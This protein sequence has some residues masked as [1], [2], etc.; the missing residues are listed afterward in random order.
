MQALRERSRWRDRRVV[1]AILA[2][3]VA[4]GFGVLLIFLATYE[5]RH[6]GRILPG[7]SVDGVSLAGLTPDEAEAR[8]RAELR[9][10]APGMVVLRDPEDE[11]TWELE[12]AELG[13]VDVA[14]SA[15][16][17]AYEVG[18]Q[19]P[20]PLRWWRQQ[21]ARLRGAEV[22]GDP[23]FDPVRARAALEALVEEVDTP[24]R[25]AAVE[26][27]EGE[28]VAR[29]ATPGRQLDVDG[30][31]AALSAAAGRP[32]P[33]LDIAL[34]LT[35]PIGA[36]ALDDLAEAYDLVTSGPLTMSFRG[37]PSVTAEEEL[38]R[39]WFA[40]EEGRGP[41]GEP[42]TSLSVDREGIRAW[43][44]PLAPL[45]RQAP[46]NVRVAVVDGAPRVVE[47]A[48]AG[49]ELDVEASI[50]AVVEAAYTEQRVGQLAVL[51]TPPGVQDRDAARIEELRELH[52]AI[53]STAA[54]AEGER[55]ALRRAAEALDGSTLA[56]GETFSLRSALGE[57]SAEAGYPA[58]WLE[59]PRHWQAALASAAFR[60]ALWA[61]LPIPERHAPAA[62][63]GHVEPPVGLD[64][65]ID[66]LGTAEDLDD[67]GE[68]RDLAIRNDLGDLLLFEVSLDEERDQLVWALYGPDEGRSVRLEGPAVELSAAPIPDPIRIPTA[69]LAPGAE[70]W[71]G[72][73]REGASASVTRVIASTG[74]GT[75]EGSRGGARDVF[76]SIYAPS[77]DVIAVGAAP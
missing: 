12:A 75:G 22:A 13:M 66:A 54:M 76:P 41:Q 9:L 1:D 44:E 61:G 32:A 10:P 77:P 55:A 21:A 59:G 35:S 16:R 58:L 4:L 39:S 45:L 51:E 72:R 65:T 11:R 5:G 30:T 3:A 56:P 34:A 6:A 47:P 24:P 60:A 69:A 38:V 71:I 43:L 37:G 70:A 52:R 18:R 49:R 14:A 27:V 2:L 17:R 63:S 46:R 8:L 42:T 20:I 36:L 40:L 25:S 57:V 23:S 68:A 50:E 28:A 48:L 67:Q 29:A 53:V 26:I 33:F 64:A 31:L 74:E 19:G 7:V 73:A 62:R 15:A